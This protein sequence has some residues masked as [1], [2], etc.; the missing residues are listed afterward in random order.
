MN[1]K[2][3]TFV[4]LDLIANKILKHPL[5]RSLNYEDVIDHAVSVLKLAK[6]PGIY[7]EDSCIVNI[8]NHL[9]AIPRQALNLKKVEYVDSVGNLTAMI[10]S[11]NTL[12]YK[13]SDLNH[14]MA[15]ARNIALS[16]DYTPEVYSDPS[17][18]KINKEVLISSNSEKEIINEFKYKI[19]A[20]HVECSMRSGKVL[21]KF[22]VLSSDQD[23]IPLIPNSESL[24]KA[25][26]NYIKV[27]VF[28][29]LV[30]MGTLSE[31]SLTRAEQEYCWYIGQAQTEFQGIGSDDEM[32]AYLNS[33]VNLFDAKSLHSDRYESSSD[34]EVIN[35]L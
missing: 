12:G 27:Q 2:S 25:I 7:K 24:I 3:V 16:G 14:K 34:Q 6:V 21:L 5:M 30:D 10:V 11:T 13:L 23:G 1:S 29:V 18:S 26:T 35:I 32:Q 9:A 33:H 15:Y 8:E 31:R 17:V 22:D 28:E 20:Q 19:N 4:S